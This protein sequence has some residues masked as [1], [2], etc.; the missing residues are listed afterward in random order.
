M[1]AGVGD[2]LRG[3]NGDPIDLRQA[4]YGFFQQVRGGVI[5]LVP[6]FV[7]VGVFQSEIRAEVNNFFP[8]FQQMRRRLAWQDP[9]RRPETQNRICSAQAI[10]ANVSQ[11][12]SRLGVMPGRAARRG[13]PS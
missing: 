1:A 3:F 7:N 4:V 11:V 12:S 6:L 10:G 8:R 2:K 5:G 9:L 13:F